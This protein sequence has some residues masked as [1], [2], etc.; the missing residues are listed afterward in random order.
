MPPHPSS[1]TPHP[2]VQGVMTIVQEDRVRLVDGL[3]RGYLF[4][5]G[6]RVR[7]TPAALWALVRDQRLVTIVYQGE[8]DLG[9]VAVA[10]RPEG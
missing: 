8:P 3:G 7:L 10:I 9:A 2:S 1:L 4:V 6:K 5:I